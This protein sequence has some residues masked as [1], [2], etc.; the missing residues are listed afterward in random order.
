MQLLKYRSIFNYQRRLIS[1]ITYPN[2]DDFGFNLQLI[3]NVVSVEEENEM[4]Y[5]I[6]KIYN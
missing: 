1:H 2:R 6:I 4:L 5:T 3:E